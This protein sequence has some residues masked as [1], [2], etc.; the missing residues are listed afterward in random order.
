MH[1]HADP[2]DGAAPS[3]AS[4]WNTIGVRGGR[5]RPELDVHLHCRNCSVYSDAAAA[6]LDRPV[7]AEY[8]IDQTRH[9][10]APSAADVSE[11]QSVVIFRI[12][13]VWFALPASVLAEVA[14]MRTVHSVP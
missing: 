3:A 12:G 2:P 1:P 6:L 9:F 7:P 10:E 11:A 8:A 5:S 14:E 4:C 13:P